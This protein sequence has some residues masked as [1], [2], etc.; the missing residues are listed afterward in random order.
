MN[1]YMIR[2]RFILTVALVT[3]FALLSPGNSS[4]AQSEN[5]ADLTDRE[6]ARHGATILTIFFDPLFYEPLELSSEQL[7]AIV[8]LQEA[9]LAED[10]KLAENHTNREIGELKPELWMERFNKFQD[11]LLPHQVE[12]LDQVY[13]CYKFLSNHG[14]LSYF[15][16]EVDD[17]P[18][19][20]GPAR[21]ADVGAVAQPVTENIAR[22][23]SLF[24]EQT[25]EHLESQRTQILDLLTEEQKATFSETIGPL[26]RGPRYGI[27]GCRFRDEL[28]ESVTELRSDVVNEIDQVLLPYQSRRLDQLFA[29]QELLQA[30]GSY[31]TFFLA[32][33]REKLELS[34]TQIET[35]ERLE[36]EESKIFSGIA[37]QFQER[38]ADLIEQEEANVLELLD[39][40][41][42]EKLSEYFGANLTSGWVHVVLPE[43]QFE[44]T[45][46]R[47]FCR[48]KRIRMAKSKLAS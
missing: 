44:N 28:K 43:R 21:N 24:H 48:K 34:T 17:S 42:R 38:I 37:S 47:W 31:P 2:S 7:K 18:I 20:L 12:S 27:V 9:A 19:Q 41:D 13:T 4:F 3:S 10:R 35:I 29:Q 39:E 1:D 40:S 11:I 30:R 33:M 22:E 45:K 36:I 14:R 23:T 8:N 15:L 26:Y 5:K 32:A 6:A 25:M 16:R 46:H